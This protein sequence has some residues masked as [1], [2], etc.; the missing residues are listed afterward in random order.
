MTAMTIRPATV[1]DVNEMAAVYNHA[2]ENTTATFDLEPETP[3]A[4][5]RWLTSETTLVALAAQRDERVVGW[6]SLVRWSARRA[7]DHC[8]EASVY[9]APTAQGEGVGLALAGAII[10][11]APAAD[12]HVVIAQIC[13]ENVAGLALADR[14]GFA[15]V[16]VLR[17]VGFKFG[18]WLNVV[19]CQRFV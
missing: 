4:R 19:V 16:G 1:D 3:D 13:T 7:Y 5:R 11:A 14:L 17:E 2:V 15:R 9:V 6:A 18:R 12:L 10:A 8:A